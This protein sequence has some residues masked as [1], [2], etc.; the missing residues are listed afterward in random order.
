MSRLA[1]PASGRRRP[2]PGQPG[3]LRTSRAGRG[4][5]ADRARGSRGGRRGLSAG[6]GARRPGDPETRRPGE[7]AEHGTTATGRA[8]TDRAASGQAVSDSAVPFRGGAHGGSRRPAASPARHE[9]PLLKTR[10]RRSGEPR[11]T[12]L[13]Y[14]RDGDDFVLTVPTGAVRG[15]PRG[16]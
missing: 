5:G 3:G 7:A 15:T 4:A 8:A 1:A 6:I 2:A 14:V 12:A 9:R 13:V 10:G 11:R 16:T